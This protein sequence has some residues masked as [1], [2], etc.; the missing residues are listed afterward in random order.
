MEEIR[1]IDI[2]KIITNFSKIHRLNLIN[3]FDY[4]FGKA[5]KDIIKIEEYK[6]TLIKHLYPNNLLE[7]EINSYSD[8]Y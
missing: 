1:W 6:Q 3:Y 4:E 5:T 2:Q 8:D 7:R